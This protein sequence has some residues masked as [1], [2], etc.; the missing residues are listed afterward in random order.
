[1][2]Q[3]PPYG[4]KTLLKSKKNIFQISHLIF[5]KLQAAKYLI[6]DFTFTLSFFFIWSKLNW[7]LFHLS[8][9]FGCKKND[10]QG[11]HFRLK[12]F[13]VEKMRDKVPKSLMSQLP[14][15]LLH[16]ALSFFIVIVP[17]KTISR[18][19]TSP[20]LPRS[21]MYSGPPPPTWLRRWLPP[22]Y[23][24]WSDRKYH[25]NQSWLLV[26]T[27]TT[28]QRGQTTGRRGGGEGLESPWSSSRI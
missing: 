8:G 3:T 27:M 4:Q 19:A 1:M 12:Y 17:I 16:S 15:L 24:H 26:M 20:L 14:L 13:D 23:N 21:P 28:D 10:G 11:W 2:W 25:L 22:P 5:W 9:I 6:Y 18:G 7:A